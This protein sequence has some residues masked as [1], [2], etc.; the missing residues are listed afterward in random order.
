MG[1]RLK[2]VLLKCGH[3]I[4]VPTYQSLR[5]EDYAGTHCRKCEGNP[6]DRPAP[7]KKK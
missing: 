6:A 4:L 7:A 5:P 2:S 1:Q 3:F